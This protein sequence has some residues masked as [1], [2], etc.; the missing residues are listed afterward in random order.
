[1]VGSEGVRDSDVHDKIKILSNPCAHGHRVSRQCVRERPPR[2]GQPEVAQS[3][4]LGLEMHSWGPP[5]ALEGGHPACKLACVLCTQAPA[6]S[7]SCLDVTES[8][9]L[10]LSP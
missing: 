6:L 3:K 7:S 4:E 2:K 10:R 9:D 5:D 1:M 8:W